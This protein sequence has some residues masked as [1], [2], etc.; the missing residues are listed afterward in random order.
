[1]VTT[2]GGVGPRRTGC[3][4]CA[5]CFVGCPH[6]AKNSTP[7]NYLYLAEQNGAVVG[8]VMV[9]PMEGDLYF[10]RLSVLPAA[11]ALSDRVVS[12]PIYGKAE[13]LNLATAASVCLYASAFAQSGS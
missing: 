5:G 12:V 3:I 2:P 10:G 4:H 11:R 6:N 13:S 7:T 1:M 9:K 8:C